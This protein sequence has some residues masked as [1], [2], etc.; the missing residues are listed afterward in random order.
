MVRIIL[1]I[2]FIPMFSLFAEEPFYRITF[3]GS[4]KNIPLETYSTN[5]NTKKSIGLKFNNWVISPNT[6]SFVN[7]EN[8]PAFFNSKNEQDIFYIKF[9]AKF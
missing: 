4:I 5:K 9:K 2:I 1:I 8:K 6:S 3:G 7:K